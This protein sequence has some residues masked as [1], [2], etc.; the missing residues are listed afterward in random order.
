M[1]P[2][3]SIKGLSIDLWNSA[4]LANVDS[5]IEINFPE[6]WDFLAFWL[7]DILRTTSSPLYSMSLMFVILLLGNCGV[8]VHIAQMV[9]ISVVVHSRGVPSGWMFCRWRCW[10]PSVGHYFGHLGSRTRSCILR[11]GRRLSRWYPLSE[12]RY[13]YGLSKAAGTLC[14]RFPV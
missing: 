10:V 2:S 11:Y 9:W 3:L 13:L 1:L 8:F 6:V 4:L 5:T 14:I 12:C 7:L